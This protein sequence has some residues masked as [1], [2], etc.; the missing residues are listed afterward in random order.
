MRSFSIAPRWNWGIHLSENIRQHNKTYW[1]ATIP[2]YIHG[3]G[4]DISA[5]GF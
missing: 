5:Q 3:L 4:L 2:Q 1:R